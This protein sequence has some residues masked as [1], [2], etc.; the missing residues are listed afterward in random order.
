[1]RWAGHVESVGREEVYTG[2][3]WGN[4][5]ERNYLEDPGEDGRITLRWTFSRR[6]RGS[7]DWI[8]LAQDRDRHL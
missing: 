4:L 1:M 6:D 5:R 8:E 7:M 3:W 2:L